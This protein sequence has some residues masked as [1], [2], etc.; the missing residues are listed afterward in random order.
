MSWALDFTVN[1]FVN[2]LSEDGAP[3]T[4]SLTEEDVDVGREPLILGAVPI[5]S[6]LI[7]EVQQSCRTP[8]IYDI[9]ACQWR[10][11]VE[12]IRDARR[13]VFVGYSFPTED[14]YGRFLIK[15]GLRLRGNKTLS[16]NY[17]ELPNRQKEINIEINKVFENLAERVEYKGAVLEDSI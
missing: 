5:K 12:A 15:E 7:R 11:F 8:R 14:V 13:V 3:L 1:N 17:Y 2:W 4:V 16:V 10:V 6:E 9:I